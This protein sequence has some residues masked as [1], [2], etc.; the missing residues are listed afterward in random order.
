MENTEKQPRRKGPT[1]GATTQPYT[2]MLEPEDA[3][4]GKSQP[5]GLSILLRR[6][7]KEAQNKDKKK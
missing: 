2:V 5:G 4:W 1:P 3:E 7:L 6:L